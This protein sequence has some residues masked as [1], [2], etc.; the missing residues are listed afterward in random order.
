MNSETHDIISCIWKM[1]NIRQMILFV[2][3]EILLLSA[4]QVL[5]VLSVKSN[6]ST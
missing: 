6:I 2:E 3:S 1:A 4:R 5:V